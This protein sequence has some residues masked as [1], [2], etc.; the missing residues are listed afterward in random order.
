MVSSKKLIKNAFL[1]DS[2]STWDIKVKYITKYRAAK[3]VASEKINNYQANDSINTRTR[4]LQRWQRAHTPQC[5]LALIEGAVV[6]SKNSLKRHSQPSWCRKYVHQSKVYNKVSHCWGLRIRINSNSSTVTTA[7]VLACFSA[8]NA[9][10]RH[11]VIEQFALACE[12]H[13]QENVLCGVNHLRWVRTTR[14]PMIYTL[15]PGPEQE[16]TL[17][18]KKAQTFRFSEFSPSIHSWFHCTRLKLYEI[19]GQIFKI[20]GPPKNVE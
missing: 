16:C 13:D 3:D 4:M 20:A 1:T 11:N 9:P 12:L 17:E 10:L 2:E 5:N 15:L 6:S 19:N 18:G 14:N 7:H 8:R